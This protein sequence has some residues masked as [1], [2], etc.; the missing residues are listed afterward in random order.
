MRVFREPD[1]CHIKVATDPMCRL[2]PIATL[3][4][5]RIRI[6][7]V[8]TPAETHLPGLL[9]NQSNRFLSLHRAF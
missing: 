5:T 6:S 3:L 2:P 9:T 7:L 4:Y 1:S 8:V